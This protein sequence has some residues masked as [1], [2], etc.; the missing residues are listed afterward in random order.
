MDK[1][2]EQLIEAVKQ[3]SPAV[4]AAAQAKVTA[5]I[6]VAHFWAWA[7]LP[8]LIFGFGLVA[9]AAW[10]E[11]KSRYGGEGVMPGVCGFFILL[12]SF[13]ACAAAWTQYI[14]MSMARDWYAI[15][16]LVELSPLK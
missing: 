11:R 16:A 1:A 8:I 5:D 6:A 3:A 14:Q 10:A 4:W 9:Y 12:G 15:R 2:L 13:I 7:S